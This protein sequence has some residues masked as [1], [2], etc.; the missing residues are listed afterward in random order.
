MSS[1]L[2][3]RALLLLSCL[4]DGAGQGVRLGCDTED[5]LLANL[6]FVR[7]VCR[8]QGEHFADDDS[9]VPTTIGTG[10][11]AAVAQRVQRDCSGLLGRSPWFAGRKAAL[12]S[13]VSSASAVPT[14][15]VTRHIVDP[16][17]G[18]ELQIHSCTSVLDD[19]LA[20]FPAPVAGQA[21][22]IINIGPSRGKVRL[23]FTELVLD[24][25]DALY[26][27][28]DGDNTQDADRCI[29]S[30]D[31]P[32]TQPVVAT[33]QRLLMR[34]L[35]AND[36]S[37][38]TSFRVA[39]SCVCADETDWRDADGDGCAAYEPA[40]A[41][42]GICADML[43]ADNQARDA[44]PRACE[45][46]EPSPCDAMPCHNGGTCAES[47]PA[48]PAGGDGHRRAQG[49]GYGPGR[50]TACS[51]PTQLSARSA[52]VTA[53]CCDE[54]DEDCSGGAPRTCHA[55]C[56]T[57]LPAYVADCSA[58][59]AQRKGGAATVVTLQSTLAMCEASSYQCTCA[60]GWTG[61]NCEAQD[62]APPLPDPNTDAFLQAQPEIGARTWVKC[63]DSA[64]DE[65]STPA[66]FHQNC[67]PYDETVLI[68]RNVLGFTFGGY[69]SCF[70]LSISLVCTPVVA[71]GCPGR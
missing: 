32:L 52:E 53:E 71:V 17:E 28:L 44:C 25:D 69:V 11:C 18:A 21:Y 49:D 16:A 34:L 47:E 35:V 7:E 5:E 23:D 27:Y 38:R 54:A 10:G 1:R 46:C 13:A 14:D 60:G 58:A 39:I 42:H 55:D 2:R 67:D 40:G 19:G 68:T 65:A 4:A 56:A 61:G 6:R 51:T 37:T 20:L 30:G 15:V 63:F 26:L 3:L 64:E 57:I 8:Q 12:D 59:V 48:A 43:T 41:K 50:D 9:L 33:G 31:L 24:G 70:A 62:T 45:A 66:V 36:R 29:G 22:A